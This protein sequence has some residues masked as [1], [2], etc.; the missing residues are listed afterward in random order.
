MRFRFRQQAGAFTGRPP[1][2]EKGEAAECLLENGAPVA[3]ANVGSKRAVA[4][5][6]DVDGSIPASSQQLPPTESRSVPLDL[7]RSGSWCRDRDV[8]GSPAKCWDKL[9]SP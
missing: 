7:K 2:P 9:D 8:V 6:F 5:G 1:N 3:R 4:D